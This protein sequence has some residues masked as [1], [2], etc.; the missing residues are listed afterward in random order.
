MNRLRHDI[1]LVAFTSLGIAGSGTIAISVLAAL[2]GLSGGERAVCVGAGLLAAAIVVS[3]AHLGR[4][5]RATLAGRGIGPSPLSNEVA[6]ALSTL[7]CGSL[8]ALEWGGPVLVVLWRVGAL[9][10]AAALLV[11]IGLVYRI[12]GQLT[13]GHEAVWSPL[14]SGLLIGTILTGALGTA[15]AGLLTSTVVGC[16][17]VDAALVALRWGS[18][19]RLRRDM[20]VAAS[21]LDRTAAWMAWR[22]ALLDLWPLVLFDGG[23]IAA[24]ALVSAAGLV[25]DRVG[26][27]TTSRQH[28]TE[29]EIERIERLLDSTP[30][31]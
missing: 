20:D 30:A 15:D 1:P 6:L 21:G 5:G 28:T 25:V 17:V 22:V 29:A 24:A 19:G 8:A 14:S 12:A 13:W 18:Y 3:L 9:A 23:S 27:Y 11:S 2:A 4:P 16:A 7:A 31:E 10:C 26:F